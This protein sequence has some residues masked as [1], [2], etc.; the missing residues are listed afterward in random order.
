MIDQIFSLDVQ[1]SCEI[2]SPQNTSNICVT[3]IHNLDPNKRG[4]S[5]QIN[6]EFPFRLLQHLLFHKA[7]QQHVHVHVP[8]GD[9]EYLY[10]PFLKYDTE[11][12]D[13]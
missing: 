12:L 13:K 11:N 1:K 10:S 9:I 6:N 7:S 8:Y 2:Y 3:G 4:G 5:M